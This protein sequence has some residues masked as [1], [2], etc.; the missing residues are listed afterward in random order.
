MS[1]PDFGIGVRIWGLVARDHPGYPAAG[2]H[3]SGW[4]VLC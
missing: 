3:Y 4:H 1:V 2:V